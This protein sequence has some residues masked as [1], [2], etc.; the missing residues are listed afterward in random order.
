MLQ[1]LK[2]QEGVTVEGLL[3][4]GG[5]TLGHR[6]IVVLFTFPLKLFPSFIYFSFADFSLS[7]SI[8]C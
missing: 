5:S 1:K 3:A 7:K 4:R 2:A 8:S 6:K